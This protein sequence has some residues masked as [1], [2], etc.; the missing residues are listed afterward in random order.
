MSIFEWKLKTFFYCIIVSLFS[1]QKEKK[2]QPV[3]PRA[4]LFEVF[5]LL[6]LFYQ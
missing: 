5:S 1:I 2:Y 4:L 3:L 6:V